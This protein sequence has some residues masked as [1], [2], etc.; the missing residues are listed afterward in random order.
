MMKKSILLVMMLLLMIAVATGCGQKPASETV[1]EPAEAE[2]VAQTE[3][4]DVTEE[5]ATE[6]PA[7][8]ALDARTVFVSPEW[9]KSVIDGQQAESDN[10]VILEASWGDVS[11]SPDYNTGHI[12]GAVHVDISSIEGEPYWNLKTAEEVE[13]A[14]LELGITS[15]KTVILYG[16]DPSGTSRVAYAY[17]W[18]GVEN[19]KVINGSL[20]A[21]T[22]A[23]YELETEE[24]LAMP[25]TEFGVQ[26]PAHPEYWTSIEDA[27][28]RLE[29][30]DNFKLVSIRSYAEFIGE[31]S[32]YS[33]IDKAAEP[34]GA[35][36]GK[37]GS[38]AYH[39][40][41]YTHENGTYITMEEM[42]TLW[43][44]LD[45]TVD[46]HLAFYCG[47]GWRA[48]IPFL[49]MY[50]NGYNDISLYDGGWYQW[51][52]DDTLAVQVGDPNTEGVVYTTVGELPNDK[53]A[54]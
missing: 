44:D 51:Q 39:M 35:V 21:W 7:V 1:A 45:F 47:T 42:E 9:V 15:D 5:T 27:A 54:K 40:E 16:A 12:P 11:N 13:T 37:A 23:G 18:A 38:D 14:M 10:Y 19:V 34:K 48:S 46:N 49:I 33:Y 24:H 52:M 32:G 28:K 53:K 26:V 22:E 30:D 4:T 50:E 36:W 29:E 25:V 20:K 3:I 41:D 6:T 43:R 2:A 8:E 31:T 17:I